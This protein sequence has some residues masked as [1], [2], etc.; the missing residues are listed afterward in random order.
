MTQNR[1]DAA[2]PAASATAWAPAARSIAFQSAPDA[3]S[4]RAHRANSAAVSGGTTRAL[5][6]SAYAAVR[7]FAAVGSNVP[8]REELQRQVPGAEDERIARDD[9]DR[10]RR[11]LASLERPGSRSTTRSGVARSAV[12]SAR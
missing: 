1:G 3:G 8:S 4:A 11:E 6:P 2:T 5:A 10:G 12:A 9:P 7:K